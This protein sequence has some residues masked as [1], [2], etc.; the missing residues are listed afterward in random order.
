MKTKLKE[1]R[2]QAGLSLEEIAKQ[3]G[4][5]R[6]HVHCLEGERGNP[7]LKLAYKIAAFLGVPVQEI[8]PDE[9]EVIEETIIVRRLK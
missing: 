9:T 1:L 6:G 5:S 7:S 3:C 8:W 4:T 2:K